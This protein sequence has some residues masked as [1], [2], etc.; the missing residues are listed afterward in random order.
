[1]EGNFYISDTVVNRPL[2]SRYGL[3]YERCPVAAAAYGTCVEKGQVNRHLSAH[4]CASEREALRQCVNK[5]LRQLGQA[6]VSRPAFQEVASAT[7]KSGA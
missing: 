4:Q 6:P 2:H 5:H 3:A 7:P 1:M